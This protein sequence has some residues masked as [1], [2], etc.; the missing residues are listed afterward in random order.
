MPKVVR[1]IVYEGSMGWLKKQLGRSMNDGTIALSDEEYSG[2]NLITAVTL[3]TDLEWDEEDI[4]NAIN[5]PSVKEEIEN[6]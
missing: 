5:H 3:R 6:D 4:L 1:L 2:E